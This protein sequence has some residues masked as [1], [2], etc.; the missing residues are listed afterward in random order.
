MSWAA[1]PEPI[2]VTVESTPHDLAKLK[3]ALE[4]LVEGSFPSGFSLAVLDSG[5][6][7]F[8]AY[9]GQACRVGTPRPITSSTSYDLASVTKVVCSATLAVLYAGRGTLSLEDPVQRWLS[10]FPRPDTTLLHLVTHTSG[11]VAHRPFFERLRG[12]AAI[13]AAVLEEAAGASPTEQVLYSDLNFMLLGW[14]LEACGGAGLDELFAAQVA[15]PLGMTRTGFRPAPDEE[16]A[17]TEL[18]G[19]QRLVPGL[20]WGEVHDGNAHALGG[21]AGHAG[22]FGPLGDLVGF[23]QQLLVPDDRVLSRAGVQAMATRW[24]GRSPEVRGLGWRLEPEDWGDWPEGTLWHTGFTGTSLLASPS[25][26]L[27][28]VLLTNAIHPRRRLEDQAEMRATVHR[29]VSEAFS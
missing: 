7:I 9:G 11:L 22:L 17:A 16:T 19:D 29:L 14:V 23:V 12:R 3:T 2:H 13:E 18:D 26:G 15:D 1:S 21:V 27:G 4:R 6:A 20:V 28:V 10:G 5:G 8:S 25:R 24:A